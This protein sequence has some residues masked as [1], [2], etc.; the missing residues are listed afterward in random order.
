MGGNTFTAPIKWN[1]CL[2]DKITLGVSRTPWCLF[3]YRSVSRECCRSSSKAVRHAVRHCAWK[4][5]TAAPLWIK[6]FQMN[7]NLPGS[8]SHC[9]FIRMLFILNIENMKQKDLLWFNKDK[10]G[11][12]FWRLFRILKAWL[13][14]RPLGRCSSGPLI[15]PRKWYTLDLILASGRGGRQKWASLWELRCCC[16]TCPQRS[17]KINESP[18]ILDPLNCRMIMVS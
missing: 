4:A 18:A 17:P 7:C 15:L 16:P 11:Q 13:C 14:W 9:I 8:S 10:T 2:R 6:T 12:I 1:L 5:G 3:I